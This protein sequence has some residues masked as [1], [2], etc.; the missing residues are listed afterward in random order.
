[1]DQLKN[2]GVWTVIAAATALLATTVQADLLS[3]YTFDGSG[4]DNPTNSI[5]GAPD[6][7]LIDEL[8]CPDSLDS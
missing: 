4:A 7:T 5:S 6:G 1:M 2:M 8:T 3:L